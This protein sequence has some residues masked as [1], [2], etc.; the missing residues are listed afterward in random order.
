LLIS[1]PITVHCE[2]NKGAE[3]LS[4]NEVLNKIFKI[5]FRN[6]KAKRLPTLKIGTKVNKMTK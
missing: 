5:L 1:Q 2:N 4:S 6:N 3:K